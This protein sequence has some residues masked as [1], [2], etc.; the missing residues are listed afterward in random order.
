LKIE[1][2]KKEN[3]RLEKNYK[4]IE[5]EKNIEKENLIKEYKENEKKKIAKIGALKE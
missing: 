3:Q 4:K 1:T 2:L 5:I